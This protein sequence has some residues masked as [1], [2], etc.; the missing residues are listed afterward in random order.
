MKFFKLLTLLLFISC[1]PKEDTMSLDFV[2]IDILAIQQHIPASITLDFKSKSI[3]FS[4]LTQM[5]IIPEDCACAFETL[6]PS[7]DFEYIHL[8]DSDFNHAK[9][10]FGKIFASEIKKINTEF[11]KNK[12]TLS[13]QYSEETR[14][15]VSFA[16][17][18]IKFSTDDFL[19]IDYNNQR[20]VYELLKIIKKNTKS[21]HN[22]KFIEYFSF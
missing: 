6:N 22:K 3:S 13:Y 17:D 18:T 1:V 10:L 8:N 9:V 15:R 19:I 16:K 5:T 7:V 20:A 11:R 4:D 12:D 14:Y 2:K 21:S